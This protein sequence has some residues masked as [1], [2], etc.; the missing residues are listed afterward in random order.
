MG[1]S[2]LETCLFPDAVERTRREFVARLAWNGHASR[3]HRVL[4]LTMA[5][6]CRNQ[7]QPS[8]ASSRRISLTFTAGIMRSTVDSTQIVA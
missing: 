6:A 3:L 5:A 1:V 2:L 4:E 8:F 7:H